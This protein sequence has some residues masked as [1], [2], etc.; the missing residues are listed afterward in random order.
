MLPGPSMFDNSNAVKFPVQASDASSVEAYQ[1]QHDQKNWVMVTFTTMRFKVLKKYMKRE[2][3]NLDKKVVVQMLTPV[4]QQIES[5]DVRNSSDPDKA[6]TEQPSAEHDQTIGKNNETKAPVQESSSSA[7]KGD[8]DANG[9][10]VDHNEGQNEEKMEDEIE[11]ISADDSEDSDTEEELDDK[12][13]TEGQQRKDRKHRGGKRKK[14]KEKYMKKKMRKE[15]RQSDTSQNPEPQEVP[16]KKPETKK[17]PEPKEELKKITL[18]R[19]DDSVST[20]GS[21]TKENNTQ[22]GTSK[23]N[24]VENEK[25]DKNEQNESNKQ[26]NQ[27]TATSSTNSHSTSTTQ[28]YAESLKKG[29]KGVNVSAEKEA[30]SGQN[31]QE[32]Q[33]SSGNNATPDNEK[34]KMQGIS[35]AG[36]ERNDFNFKVERKI[37]VTRALAK[38]LKYNY[39]VHSSLPPCRHYEFFYDSLFNKIDHLRSLIIPDHCKDHWFQYDGIVRGQPEQ[40]FF[41]SLLSRFGYESYESDLRKDCV[42]FIHTYF[43]QWHNFSPKA[44]QNWSGTE[45]LERFSM[46]ESGLKRTYCFTTKMWYRNV[47]KFE[48]FI[49]KV[50]YEILEPVLMGICNSVYPDVVAVIGFLCLWYRH[51]TP[52]EK[53]LKLNLFRALLLKPNYSERTCPQFDRIKEQFK[54][55]I[56]L[57]RDSLTAL[58]RSMKESDNPIWLYSIPLF[59]FLMD[60]SK[61]FQT[62]SDYD[63]HDARKSTWWG[64]VEIKVELDFLKGKSSWKISETDILQTLIPLFEADYLLPRTFLA[65]LT[66]NRYKE[67]VVQALPV[68]VVLAGYLFHLRMSYYIDDKKLPTAI[69]CLEKSRE[70]L[71]SSAL[72][73]REQIIGNQI[74]HAYLTVT[75]TTD[76]LSEV[77]KTAPHKTDLVLSV[78]GCYVT[79]LA[80]YELFLEKLTENEK[81]QIKSCNVLTIFDAGRKEIIQW[82]QRYNFIR[83]SPKDDLGVW[84]QVLL[85]DLPE[86]TI[87][88]SFLSEVKDKL[89]ETMFARHERTKEKFVDIYCE[90]LEEFSASVQ[91]ILGKVVFEALEKGCV[92]E[93]TILNSKGAWR[94]G[95][96]LSRLFEGSW[97]KRNLEDSTAILKFTLSWPSF[98]HFI[99]IFLPNKENSKEKDAKNEKT[100]K[101]GQDKREKPATIASTDNHPLQSSSTTQTNEN[102]LKRSQKDGKNTNSGGKDKGTDCTAEKKQDSN[103]EVISLKF[104]S[105]LLDF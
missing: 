41:A 24:G 11:V 12:A 26:G 22:Q 99:K 57:V 39:M 33:A 7:P 32:N 53:S 51:S 25:K 14:G 103:K 74:I 44:G 37:E 86:G 50:F 4:I 60:V 42:E 100:N 23:Q 49:G 104:N 29:Q 75:V 68:E 98:V 95:N 43:P 77:M 59:H 30:K 46:F 38:R 27:M 56:P 91:D 70:K 54:G 36:E 58:I 35:E 79:A 81:K 89:Q 102:S 93:D 67:S 9:N 18:K 97:K 17:K 90:N 28:T 8:G 21:S 82:L 85:T 19:L 16:K 52:L 10:T 69:M 80:I 87:K 64:N 20:P 34:D 55:E 61:P 48:T 65:A 105:N 1:G 66:F 96:L 76:L 92:L 88:V 15:N 62:V 40:S 47:A 71:L 72:L 94:Y 83:N 13:G 45:M 31:G 63:K 3:K 73:E 84:N 2:P 6:I 78:V 5:L 101:D